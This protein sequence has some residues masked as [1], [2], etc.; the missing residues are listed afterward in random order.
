LGHGTSFLVERTVWGGGGG[1]PREGG[2]GGGGGGPAPG[3][4]AI[5]PA[6]IWSAA[7]RLGRRTRW[8]SSRPGVKR[9]SDRKVLRQLASRSLA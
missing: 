6:A 7:A 8:P 3:L 4:A 9:L 2:L 5:D 1:T